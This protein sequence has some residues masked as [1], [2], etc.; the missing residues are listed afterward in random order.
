MGSM[1]RPRDYDRVLEEGRVGEYAGLR[2]QPQTTYPARQDW[3]L[4][5]RLCNPTFPGAWRTVRPASQ[6]SCLRVSLRGEV[7]LQA[8]SNNKY[9]QTIAHVLVLDGTSVNHTL[10][11]DGW[12]WWYRK[13][14]PLD[15]ELEK[16]EKEAREARKGL[17]AD[18]APIP[19][20]VYRKARRA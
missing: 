8:Y 9:V 6:A 3:R 12:C 13:Y 4:R 11:E 14:A 17:W 20:W 10:V 7:T 1:V 5:V 16:L 15:V 18:P 2:I 19:P